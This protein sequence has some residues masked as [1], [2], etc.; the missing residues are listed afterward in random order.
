VTLTNRVEHRRAT[1]R[2]RNPSPDGE[3]ESHQKRKSELHNYPERETPG[4]DSGAKNDEGFEGST[5][6]EKKTEMSPLLRQEYQE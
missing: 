2:R 1:F 3:G 4:A 6:I 5:K